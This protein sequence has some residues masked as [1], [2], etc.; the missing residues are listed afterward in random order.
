MKLP[1]NLQMFAASQSYCLSFTAAAV[2]TVYLDLL[3][4]IFWNPRNNFWEAS[5]LA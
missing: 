4:M 5:N 1:T 3:V 2:A